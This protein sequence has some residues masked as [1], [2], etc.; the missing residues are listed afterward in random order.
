MKTFRRWHAYLTAQK[1]IDK[2]LAECDFIAAEVAQVHD[3]N[4]AN[5]RVALRRIRAALQAGADR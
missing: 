2:A 5:T 4:A 1:R 3:S